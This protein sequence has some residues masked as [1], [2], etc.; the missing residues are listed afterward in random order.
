ML[1]KDG[2]IVSAAAPDILARTPAGRRGPWFVN[3]ADAPLLARLAAE[4][5][6]GSLISK[7]SEVVGFNDIPAAI[8]RNRT[9]PRIGK[10]VADFSH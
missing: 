5:A 10:V 8:E 2:A 3:K 6:Q 1:S 7:L 9:G 4:I